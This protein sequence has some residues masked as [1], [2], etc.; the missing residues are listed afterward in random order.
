MITRAIFVLSSPEAAHQ[1]L[2]ILPDLRA[3]GLSEAT[4]LHLV[5][6]K[7]G[8]AE[9]MPELA[10]WV[11][12]FEAAIPKVEL[13]LKRE[14]RSSGSMSWRGCGTYTSWFS[15]AYPTAFAGTWSA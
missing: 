15:R 14:T 12:H 4:L 6:A 8:P 3:L 1:F 9:P 11:R 13:A 5:E 7:R 10:N 2:R